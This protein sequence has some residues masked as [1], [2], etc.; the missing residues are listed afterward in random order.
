[1]NTS[2]YNT[3]IRDKLVMINDKDGFTE[4]NQ[5]DLHTLYEAF[6]EFNI[7]SFFKYYS[8]NDY[9]YKNLNENCLH[10]A[11][12]AGLNDMFEVKYSITN[13]FKGSGN[14]ELDALIRGVLNDCS[15]AVIESLPY[16]RNHTSVFSMTT[17]WDN[18]AMWGLY[19]NSF[20]GVCFEYSAN[21]FF[22]CFGYKLAPVVY[23]DTMPERKMTEIIMGR[24][25]ISDSAFL[26]VLQIPGQLPKLA[27]DI[28]EQIRLIQEACTTKNTDWSYEEEWRVVDFSL[29]GSIDE[30]H[31]L[32]G[33]NGHNI[34]GKDKLKPISITM[35]SKI[36]EEEREKLIQ[37]AKS[38]NMT[39]Y[40]L[41][42]SEND[43]SLRRDLIYQAN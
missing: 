37:T 30:K 4:Q 29:S 25:G 21:N 11:E 38:T 34:V 42:A 6:Q 43:Y 9:T 27:Q 20:K 1:M 28:S 22:D 40:Q 35:G 8:I 12:V 26:S 15:K 41:V 10:I 39:L 18:Q 23:S 14:Q 3:F 33:E 2:E 7:G 5:K 13:N 36:D 19:G 24:K 32:N 16:I 31:G 17:R